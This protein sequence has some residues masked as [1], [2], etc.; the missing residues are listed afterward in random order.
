M[1]QF[2]KCFGCKSKKA[3]FQRIFRWWKDRERIVE[4]NRGTV[5]CKKVIGIQLG[6]LIKRPI[7]VGK[8]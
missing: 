1:H 5:G 8:G 4:G 6:N 2:P 3:N 7:K